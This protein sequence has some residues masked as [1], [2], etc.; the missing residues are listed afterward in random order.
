LL[1]SPFRAVAIV[2]GA[3][4]AAAA[5]AQGAR[6]VRRPAVSLLVTG[7]AVMA[8][9]VAAAALLIGVANE[10]YSS[11]PLMRILREHRLETATLVVYEGFHPWS[12][13]HAFDA[14]DRI[15]EADPWTLKKAPVL[16]EVVVTR[17]SRATELGSRLRSDYARIATIRIRRKEYEVYELRGR[18]GES[19]RGVSPRNPKERDGTAGRKRG[20]GGAARPRSAR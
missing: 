16:P 1:A 20:K 15:R 3:A 18:A 12:R 8:G 5:L 9:P 11:R 19:G 4:A 6:A 7:G 14:V 10:V 17:A 13:D 2:G